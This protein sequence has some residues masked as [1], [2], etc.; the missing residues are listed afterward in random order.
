VEPFT[1]KDDDLYNCADCK[2]N[3]MVYLFEMV[4]QSLKKIGKPQQVMQTVLACVFTLVLV[5]QVVWALRFIPEIVLNETII[6]STS[7]PFISLLVT[8]I[9]AEVVGMTFVVVR[10]VFRSP[11]S[12]LIDVLKDLINKDNKS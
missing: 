5:A 3:P 9:L 11:I 7:L 4:F 8:A 6:Q 2:K 1:E 10:Y 12:E